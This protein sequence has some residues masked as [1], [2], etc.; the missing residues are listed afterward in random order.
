MTLYLDTSAIIPTLVLEPTGPAIDRFIA[1][2]RERL[3]VSEF[4]ATEVASAFSR[5]HRTGAM[6]RAETLLRLAD[7]DTW[8]AAN[9]ATPDITAADHRLAGLYVRRF[10]LALRAPDALHLAICARLGLTLV[11]LDRRLAAAAVALGVAVID[12]AAGR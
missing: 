10:D 9:T 4:A 5:L 11:T 2:N 1:G 12:P 7:F 3:A 8:R 6:D